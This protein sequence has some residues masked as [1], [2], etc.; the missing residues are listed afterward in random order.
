MEKYLNI[1]KV[2]LKYQFLPHIVVAI[3]MCAVSPFIMGTENLDY[4]SC[5]KILE[6]YI[7][8][9]GI[10]LFVPVFYPDQDQDIKDL[11]LSKKESISTLHAIRIIEAVTILGLFI[12]LYLTF[13]KAGNCQFPFAQYYYGTMS[14]CIFLG[15][16]G[17]LA[18]SIIDN[19]SVAY[20]IP[21]LYYLICYGSG[22]KY[23][24]K[25]YLFS[26][27]TGTVEDKIYLMIGGIFMIVTG[28]LIRRKSSTNMKVIVMLKDV[29][30]SIQLNKV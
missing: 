13:L 14:S 2:Y 1:T 16:I 7:S 30:K 10:I 20:A 28:V 22:Y 15:G 27:M 23:L 3:V 11:I 5:A 19:I 8:L 21:I 29:F 17:I 12:Y 4:I 6:I 24:G 26:M 18:Y 25:F 9:L